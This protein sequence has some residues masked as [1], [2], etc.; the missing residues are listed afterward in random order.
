MTP[1]KAR[2]TITPNTKEIAPMTSRCKIPYRA[3]TPCKAKEIKIYEK[4]IA[5]YFI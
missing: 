4:S 1:D 2:Q 5:N 3:M